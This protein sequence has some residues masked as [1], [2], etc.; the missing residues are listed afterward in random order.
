MPPLGFG[1]GAEAEKPKQPIWVGASGQILYRFTIKLP[2]GFSATLPQG[3]NLTDQFATYSS[4]YSLVDGALEA[5][6]KLVVKQSKIGAEVWPAYQ[7]FAK[8]LQDDQA[9]SIV[10]GKNTS[11]GKPAVAL[12]NNPEAERL[13]DQAAQSF[14]THDLNQIRDLLHQAE[15]LDP[16]QTRLWMMYAYLEL[17]S[18]N[19]D[20]A[21]TYASKEVE[22]H[23]EETVA[24]Q[25]FAEL[26]LRV[27]RKA[28]AIEVLTNNV[29]RHPSDT[30][31][32]LRLAGLL[33]EAKQYLNL[34]EM[35]EKPIAAA[36][37]NYDLQVYKLDAL[38]G[39][40]K[41]QEGTQE[42]HRIA[43]EAK[44]PGIWN[45]VAYQLA[46]NNTA[47]DFAF[48]LATKTVAQMEQD[49]VR[50]ELASLDTEKLRS[51]DT[52]ASAW[53][54]LGWV[55]LRQGDLSKARKYVEAAWQLS[56]RSEIGNHLGEIYEQ[57]G[58]HQAAIHLWRL[59]LA[60]NNKNEIVSEHLRKAGLSISEPSKGKVSLREQPITPDEELG[61]L[62][63]A[64]VSSL[65]KQTGSAE[66]Y[67]IVSRERIED[68]QFISGDDHLKSAGDAVRQADYQFAFPDE[69]PEKIIR[70]GILSCSEY[71]KP[72]CNLTFLLPSTVRLDVVVRKNN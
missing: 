72:S 67:V 43:S 27:N 19:I 68:I 8:G 61:R 38:L 7:K 57:Q 66:F 20:N 26:L 14:Q 65:S 69:G 54:T 34:L 39:T 30:G 62:R 45:N 40:G 9:N 50:A 42:A 22:N 21:L 15:R 25:A 16:K 33:S 60:A 71:T 24:Y 49:S 51:V 36:P 41:K 55:Y 5:E 53:D 12:N 32:A 31:S 18:G 6:R 70:R 4:R 48:E 29:A 23:P 64:K 44:T 28:E 35:L 13:L 3:S 47:L 46:D 17:N 52:L 58:Q 10:L 11:G 63:T 37:D 59:A 2:A 56:Q 1:P